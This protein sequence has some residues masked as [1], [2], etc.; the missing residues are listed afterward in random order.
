MSLSLLSISACQVSDMIPIVRWADSSSIVDAACGWPRGITNAS[1]GCTTTS[2]TGSPTSSQP[3]LAMPG[4]R[5][6]GNSD[7]TSGAQMRHAL[8]P[9]SCTTITSW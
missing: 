4:P 3:G 9:L 6:W 2:I 5:F 1:P 7:R 8:V